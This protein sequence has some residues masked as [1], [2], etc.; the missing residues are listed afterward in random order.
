MK[1]ID[2]QRKK[3][4]LNARAQKAYRLGID[5]AKDGKSEKDNPYLSYPAA[6]GGVSLSSWWSSGFTHGTQA[7]NKQ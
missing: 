7:K 2:T 3:A 1:V 5:A 4:T 6:H